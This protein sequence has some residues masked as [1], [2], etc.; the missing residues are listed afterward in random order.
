MKKLIVL[1]LVVVFAAALV[2]YAFAQEGVG[3]SGAS[4][5]KCQM[6]D[7]AMKSGRGSGRMSVKPQEF[8]AYDDNSKEA[9]REIAGFKIKRQHNHYM[10]FATALVIGIAV[11]GGAISQSKVAAAAMEGIAR[12]PEASSKIFTPLII[13]LALIESLVIY[14][15]VIAFLLQGK[16]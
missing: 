7:C 4:M 16:M 15:L 9:W 11:F 10:A 1:M 14:A 2:S 3:A 8:A 13:S 12:N 6:K 5:S